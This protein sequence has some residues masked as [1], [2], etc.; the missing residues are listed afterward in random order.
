VFVCALTCFDALNERER[1]ER[2]E[3]KRREEKK[4]RSFTRSPDQCR[5]YTDI[6]RIR[7]EE[8]EKEEILCS[9]QYCQKIDQ[10]IDSSLSY[11]SSFFLLVFESN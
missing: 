9:S 2:R 5:F 10:S 11:S 1:G 3:E 8:Q 6:Y 7:T 4:N